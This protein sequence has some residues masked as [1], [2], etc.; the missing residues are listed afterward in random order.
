MVDFAGESVDAEV[1]ADSEDPD[2]AE[3]SEAA[4]LVS[5]FLVS[6]LLSAP[7]PVWVSDELLSD[8]LLS[9]ELDAD[10]GA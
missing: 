8:E 10:L 3:E 1:V 6:P 2:F 4:G 7:A 5:A 9:D